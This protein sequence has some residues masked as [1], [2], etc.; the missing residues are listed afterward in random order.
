MTSS[1]D[2]LAPIV[3]AR[4][5]GSLYFFMNMFAPFT[6]LYL[7]SRFVVQGDAAATAANIMASESLYRIGIA[8]N[9]FNAL[10]QIFLVLALYQL[11]KV[12][13]KNIASLMVIFSLVSVPI[14]MLNELT[15]L[16]VLQLL[17]KAVYI[18]L[19][20]LQAWA[21]L[22]VQLHDQGLL[23]AQIF[24]G[25]WLFPMGYLVYKSGF[26]PKSIGVLLIIACFGYVISSFGRILGYNVDIILY[27]SWGE[28]LLLLWLLIKGVD[29]E[30]WKER[31]AKVT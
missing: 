26:L 6:L 31:A 17:S 30:R 19:E 1:I 25:L 27:T 7:P 8:L 5:A 22:L 3:R 24:W 14:S 20:Q 23:I 12:V 4:I 9:L 29:T 15:Q 21:Y 28:V 13:S 10:G 16:A 11:L 2:K 18:P